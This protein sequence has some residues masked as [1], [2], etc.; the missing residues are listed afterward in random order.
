MSSERAWLILDRVKMTKLEPL[1]VAGTFTVP[2]VHFA[3]TNKGRSVAWASRGK[4]RFILTTAERDLPAEPDYGEEW[5]FADGIP[6]VPS[7]HRPENVPLESGP[8]TEDQLTMVRRGERTLVFLGFVEYRDI[9]GRK[10]HLTRHCLIWSEPHG[11]NHYRGFRYGG[12]P[13]YNQM[14]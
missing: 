7:D 9:F 3:W 4:A 12:P 6:I 10:V 11:R 5:T 13:A 14:T 1:P 8:L 2:H